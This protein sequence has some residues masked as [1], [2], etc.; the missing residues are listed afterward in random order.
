M[1]FELTAPSLFPTLL[2]IMYF[3][4]IKNKKKVDMLRFQT[5]CH[6]LGTD[7]SNF[8]FKF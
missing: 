4:L 6:E 7:A 8:I 1:S 2:V 5:M 3:F